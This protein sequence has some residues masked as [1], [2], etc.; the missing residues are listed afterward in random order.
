[1]N[2]VGIIT[3]LSLSL[4][5]MSLLLIYSKFQHQTPGKLAMIIVFFLLNAVPLVY[6]V[7]TEQSMGY[8]SN[9]FT[10]GSAFM[11]VWVI[12]AVLLL[13]GILFRVRSGQEDFF[14]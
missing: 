11:F 9:F 8:A 1:M 3:F 14:Y 6:I 5:L 10:I 12:T 13:F 7:Y 4:L 2:I